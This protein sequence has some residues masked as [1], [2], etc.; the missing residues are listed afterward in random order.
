MNDFGGDRVETDR[1]LAAEA[2]ECQRC[3]KKLAGAARYLTPG[4]TVVCVPCWIEID[5]R[6]SVS[7]GM[8]EGTLREEK[9]SAD[10]IGGEHYKNMPI[11][12]S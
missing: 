10:Q 12:P 9:P 3:G 5:S 7:S 6:E 11:Q 1:E 2:R 8:V 4:G